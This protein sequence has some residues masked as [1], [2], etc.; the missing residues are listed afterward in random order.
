MI[1]VG[2]RAYN[3]NIISEK[4]PYLSA[5]A[6]EDVWLL[7]SAMD[8][9]GTKKDAKSRGEYKAVWL[10]LCSVCLSGDVSALALDKIRPSDKKKLMD[11]F[12]QL[13]ASAMGMPQDGKKTS[14]D[15]V[16]TGEQGTSSPDVTT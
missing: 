10:E 4:D 5:L 15:S 6:V 13:A 12:G 7:S 9:L 8:E 3:P 1:E 14:G 16:T 2:G 11:F